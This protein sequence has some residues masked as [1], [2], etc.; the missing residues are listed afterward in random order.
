MRYEWD[1]AKSRSNLAKHGLDFG[2]AEQVL[3][4]P[5]VTFLDDRFDY[6]EKRLVT[7][8]LLAGRVVV[9]AHA[10]R[11][12]EATR[13]ISMRKANDREQKIYQKRLGDA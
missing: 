6:G 12:E 4:G 2:D 8:G 5:C 13:I 10:P 11:G 1:D 9:I 3:S 7:L